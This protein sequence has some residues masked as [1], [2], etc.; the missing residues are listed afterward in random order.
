MTEDK[1]IGSEGRI[2]NFREVNYDTALTLL[3]AAYVDARHR[4]GADPIDL[5]RGMG[6]AQDL[7]AA[8]VRDPQFAQEA[9]S[10]LPMVSELVAEGAYEP[11]SHI[12]I[13]VERG[14]SGQGIW[15]VDGE[16]PNASVRWAVEGGIH[17]HRVAHAAANPYLAFGSLGRADM[18]HLLNTVMVPYFQRQAPQQPHAQ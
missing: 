7:L 6:E 17:H 2:A 4:A 18:L 3:Q 5:G 9:L 11:G 8:A 15:R 13:S 14:T 10:V 12:H 1:S 16:V